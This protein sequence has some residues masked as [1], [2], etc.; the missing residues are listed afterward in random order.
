MH[1]ERLASLAVLLSAIGF[2]FVV[3]PYGTETV[4]YG[5][6][7]PDTFPRA[8]GWIVIVLS[9]IQLFNPFERRSDQIPSFLAL[10]RALG[11]IGFTA[12]CA[13]LIPRAGFLPASMLLA[14]GTCLIVHERRW[15]V[16]L[17]ACLVMPMVIW[18]TVTMILDRPLP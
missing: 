18:A 3:V 17:A 9:A 2:V 6:M 8:L 13:W 10:L 1:T 11:A 4:D 14:T 15:P 16:F 7:S 12:F 5:A